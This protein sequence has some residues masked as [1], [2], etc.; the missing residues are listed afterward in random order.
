V[1]LLPFHH[2]G[3][4][5]DCLHTDEAGGCQQPVDRIVIHQHAAEVQALAPGQGNGPDRVRNIA[6][7]HDG[8][9]Q[10]HIGALVGN[11]RRFAIWND[12]RFRRRCLLQFR[13]RRLVVLQGGRGNRCRRLGIAL[14]PAAVQCRGQSQDD[15]RHRGQLQNVHGA[16]PPRGFGWE[17]HDR[18]W[19]DNCIHRRCLL[20]SRGTARGH[21]T[22][23]ARP[24]LVREG[25]PRRDWRV[26]EIPQ[27]VQ[28]VSLTHDRAP[29]SAV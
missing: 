8:R 14:E 20:L 15:H 2:A 11:H 29:D 19:R 24:Q 26:D 17:C 5:I 22:H 12:R 16:N 21:L 10:C 28:W 18:S 27:V 23:E 25:F 13:C 6:R 3:F 1:R 4:A 7:R 9:L